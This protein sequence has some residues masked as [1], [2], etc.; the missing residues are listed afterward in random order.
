M[1]KIHFINFG[2]SVEAAEG[3]S[4]LEAAL[5]SNIPLDHDCGGN[6][7]C[8]TCHILV[9]EGMVN[10]VPISD[11]EVSLL[12]ANDKMG[13]KSRLGC[14]ARLKSGDVSVRIPD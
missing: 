14:Q 8:T 13:P 5:E 1:P 3:T 2:E 4:V 7:A 9:E 11:D 10:L 6:C 12:E